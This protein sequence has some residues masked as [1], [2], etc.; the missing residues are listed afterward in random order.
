MAITPV[1]GAVAFA[2]FGS[3]AA[4]AIPVYW[5]NVHASRSAEA[6][7]GLARLSAA[8]IA[9]AADKA[10]PDAFPP[11]APL[12]P[13]VVAR[14]EA[15]IDPPGAWDGPTWKA[16]AFRAAP[17]GVPHRFSFAFD[18]TSSA[19]LSSF[20]ATAHA[21]QDGDGLMSIFEVHGHDDA[22]GPAAD[23]GMYVDKETE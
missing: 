21:D 5:E 15:A 10:I 2:I 13:S 23:P 12:T 19:T 18:S 4:I 9:G 1:E 11:S 3:L 7:D 16:L 17:E 8:A 14:G 20:G 6:T 22:H